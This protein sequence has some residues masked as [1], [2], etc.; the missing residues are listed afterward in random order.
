MGMLQNA[1][2]VQEKQIKGLVFA[3]KDVVMVTMKTKRSVLR[4]T[5]MAFVM[6]AV[7]PGPFILTV[8]IT[9]YKKIE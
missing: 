3:T 2:I 8:T 4:L 6:Y 1:L 7:A 5:T 9:I